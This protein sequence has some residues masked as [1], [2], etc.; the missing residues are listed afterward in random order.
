MRR[1]VPRRLFLPRKSDAR[2]SGLSNWALLRRRSGYSAAVPER[3]AAYYS[4]ILWALPAWSSQYG[5]YTM[6][7][8]MGAV[9]VPA[10]H[11]CASALG[12]GGLVYRDRCPL[13]LGRGRWTIRESLA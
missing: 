3:L 4:L 2:S 5:A 10:A 11:K 9:N 7:N 6:P 13:P 12:V 1:Q 8:G